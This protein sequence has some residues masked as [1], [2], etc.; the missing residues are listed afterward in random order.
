MKIFIIWL[1]TKYYDDDQIK[2]DNM[3]DRDK[4]YAHYFKRETSIEEATWET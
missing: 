3:S 2:E 4:K 1:Y